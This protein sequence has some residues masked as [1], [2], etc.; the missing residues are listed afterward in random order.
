MRPVCIALLAASL[1]TPSFAADQLPPSYRSLI[2]AKMKTFLKD[3]YS[4]RD[5]EITG[6]MQTDYGFGGHR[7]GVCFRLNAKNQYGAYNGVTTYV[8]G[9]KGRDVTVGERITTDCDSHGWAPF[10]ELNGKG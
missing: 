6:P 7:P 3:P 2:V 10:P 8:A 1:A 9:F 4:V 5:A